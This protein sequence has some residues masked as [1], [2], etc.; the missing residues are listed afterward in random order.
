MKLSDLFEAK[1]SKWEVSVEVGP[2]Q[3]VTIEVNA[4]NKADAEKKAMAEAK[5]RKLNSPMLGYAKLVNEAESAPFRKNQKV[6]LSDKGLLGT[7][8]SVNKA[9]QFFRVKFVDG[10]YADVNFNQAH[11][12]KKFTG[13]IV[14]AKQN[15]EISELLQHGTDPEEVAQIMRIP[16]DTILQLAPEK[17]FTEEHVAEGK[18]RKETAADAFARYESLKK[19][20]AAPELLAKVLAIANSL[21][22]EQFK[23]TQSNL[24]AKFAGSDWWEEV[25]KMYKVKEEGNKWVVVSNARDWKQTKD[26]EFDTKYEALEQLEKLVKYKAADRKAGKGDIEKDFERVDALRKREQV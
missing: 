1:L 26:W 13:Q 21:M 19:S 15:A 5:R 24:E 9:W 2:H 3:F 6:V 8:E 7:V 17:S 23:K 16:I 25:K 18:M 12:L 14:T 11:K 20:K 10:R 4:A 22:D